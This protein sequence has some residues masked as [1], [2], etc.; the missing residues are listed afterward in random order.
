MVSTVQALNIPAFALAVLGFILVSVSL[1]TPAWQVAYA[2]ELQ[3]WIQSGLFLNCQ[4]RPAGMR[5]CTFTYTKGNY[6]HYTSSDAA[7]IGTPSFYAWQRTLLHII[8]V[9]QVCAFVAL[10][11]AFVVLITFFIANADGA[12]K[13]SS[14]GF[15]IA[16]GLA[17]L[18]TLGSNVAFAMYSQMVHYRFYTVSV[19]GIYEKHWGYSYYLE[20]IGSLLYGI[21]F[22]V[23]VCLVVHLFRK[24]SMATNDL[25]KHQQY[26]PRWQQ[27]YRMDPDDEYFAMRDL[28]DIPRKGR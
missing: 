18:L 9:G 16:I 14:V 13:I 25:P 12:R 6:D 5:T 1:V 26:I 4:I 19:S 15:S 11:C 8:L 28:P 17:A 22:V 24:D 27:Q 10:I 23:S 7:S 20:L 3:Q 2:I 21:S